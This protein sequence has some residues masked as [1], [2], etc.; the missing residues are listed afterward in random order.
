[1]YNKLREHCYTKSNFVTPSLSPQMGSAEE[2]GDPG[3]SGA[4]GGSGSGDRS[5]SRKAHPG[6]LCSRKCFSES[7]TCSRYFSVSHLELWNPVDFSKFQFLD[8]AHTGL[9]NEPVNSPVEHFFYF[10]HSG[11][12]GEKT[13]ILIVEMNVFAMENIKESGE[14]VEIL[15]GN[16]NGDGFVGLFEDLRE[17]SRL[18]TEHLNCFR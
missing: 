11:E 13:H 9:L 1:M 16:R 15:D 8:F 2:R 7:W 6:S 5:T 4:S 17:D 10:E 3:A 18:G 12:L 14:D